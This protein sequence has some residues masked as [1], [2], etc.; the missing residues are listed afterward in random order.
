M[1]GF[2]RTELSARALR[3]VE[4]ARR[5]GPQTLGRLFKDTPGIVQ[6]DSDLAVVA[7]EDYASPYWPYVPREQACGAVTAR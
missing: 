4:R 2:V 3:E 5:E 6:A 7:L 1:A